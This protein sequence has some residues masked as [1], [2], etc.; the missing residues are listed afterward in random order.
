M[1]AA[2]AAMGR[3]AAS[4]RQARRGGMAMLVLRQLFKTFIVT[5]A[6]MLL[7]QTLRRSRY[8][9]MFNRAGGVLHA[10]HVGDVQF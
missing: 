5:M 8:W 3:R 2:R 7:L 9:R 4:C 10:W 1:T 6:T